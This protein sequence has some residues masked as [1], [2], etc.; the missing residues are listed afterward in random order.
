M[1]TT[2]KVIGAWALVQYLDDGSELEVYFSFGTYDEENNVDSYGVNDDRIFFYCEGEEDLKS[3]MTEGME[4]FIVKGY[5]LE[6]QTT[7]NN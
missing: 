1:S 4:D 3:L 2:D 6:F 7:S 5:F